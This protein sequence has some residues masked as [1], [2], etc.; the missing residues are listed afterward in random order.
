MIAWLEGRLREKSP[1][2]IVLDVQGVG[3]ELHVPLS[4]F[5]TLPDLGKTVS[6]LVHTAVREDAIQLF[7]FASALEKELFHLLLRA[8]RVGPKLAQ[9]ILSGMEPQRL[10]RV[11]READAKGLRKAPGVGPKLAE[12]IAVELR[13][14]AEELARR[15]GAATPERGGLAPATVEPDEELLSALVNLGYPRAQAER[16]VATALAEAPAEAGL[17]SLIRIA[18]RQLAP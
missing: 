14:P 5:E 18:L 4:T 17:E 16:V 13:D 9:S 1:T 2:R 8:S 11:L 7:G 12:R 6:L 3:Y 10:L 15:T